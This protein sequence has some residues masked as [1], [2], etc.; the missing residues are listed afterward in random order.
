MNDDEQQGSK[1]K[2]TVNDDD[3]MVVE[4]QE[5]K[6]PKTGIVQQ[7]GVKEKNVADDD[8]RAVENKQQKKEAEDDEQQGVEENNTAD[9]DIKA[10][11][12]ENKQQII[13]EEENK[14]QQIVEEENK[15]Q[16]EDKEEKE[17][18]KKSDDDE[19]PPSKRKSDLNNNEDAK[20]NDDDNEDVAAA[21]THSRPIKK[22]KT[23]YFIFMDERR[24]AIQAKFPGQ[25]VAVISRELGTIWSSLADEEKAVYQERSAQDKE[26][27]A[28]ELAENISNGIDNTA[29]QQKTIDPNGI[30]LPVNRIRKIC[31][32]DPDV[33]NLSKEATM[34]I[35]KCAELAVIHLGQE[36]V[37]VAQIQN[38]RTVMAED[39]AQ[40]CATREQFLFLREDVKDL[41][42]EQKEAN[43]N[44]KTSK[45]SSAMTVA[46]ANSKPLT[47]YFVSKK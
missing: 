5:N 3:V 20:N 13:L 44:N 40:V 16:N 1:D 33:Q 25:T 6:Q 37:K 24:P 31:K 22:A 30:V 21:V 35:T 15:Q 2:N 38:R 17:N 18:D 14:E 47:S 34:L 29:L 27:Y 11:E 12:E 39:V 43:K 46:A 19:L 36:A 41:V 26:R 8:A 4:E 10:V 28:K 45:E 32:L 42:R 23:G 7:Q 9:D